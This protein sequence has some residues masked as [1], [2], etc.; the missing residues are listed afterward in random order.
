MCVEVARMT[1]AEA[2]AKGVRYIKTEGADSY[3]STASGFSYDK[4]GKQLHYGP[5]EKM[6]RGAFWIEAEPAHWNA[7]QK[8]GSIGTQQSKVAVKKVNKLYVVTDEDGETQTFTTREDAEGEIE[9]LL[10]AGVDASIR[11]FV[12]RGF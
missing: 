10:D 5:S 8:D 11:V 3:T 6:K 7:T 12:P 1:F 9:E 4:T 2:K